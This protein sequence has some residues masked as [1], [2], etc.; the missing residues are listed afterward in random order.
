MTDQPS[1]SREFYWNEWFPWLILLRTVPVALTARGMARGGVGMIATT[2]G[3]RAIG[4]VFTEAESSDPVIRE[5]REAV[6]QW[7][8]DRSLELSV[9]ATVT[10][11]ADLFNWAAPGIPKAP[12]SLW[13][14]L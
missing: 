8:W 13:Q 11:A 14:Y 1:K 12:V 5:W 9:K 2:R 10:S 3:W 7:P 4:W 6:D